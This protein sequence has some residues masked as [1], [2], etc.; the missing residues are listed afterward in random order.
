[1]QNRYIF[2]EQVAD[3]RM[4]LVTSSSADAFGDVDFGSGNSK[5]S[6]LPPEWV[7]GV[8]E[9][10]YEISRIK[11]RTRELSSLYDRHLNRPSMD[12]DDGEERKIKESSQQLAQMFNNCQRLVQQINAKSA[13]GT[14]QERK[15]TQNILSSLASQLQDQT[16]AFRKKQVEYSNRCARREANSGQLFD[17][18]MIL[19]HEAETSYADGISPDQVSIVR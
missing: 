4:A 13:L 8:E 2:S 18:T 1:M 10:Q 14:A 11:Q 19:E 16:S 9:I 3:D 12:D 15:L 17:M 7:D 6:R 5:N